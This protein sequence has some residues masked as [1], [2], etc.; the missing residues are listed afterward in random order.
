M[1]DDEESS[2]CCDDDDGFC[3]SFSEAEVA[4]LALVAAII[5]MSS[6]SMGFGP[7]PWL[8]MG[9]LIP[10]QA[11]LPWICLMSDFAL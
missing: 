5:H 1:G 2:L 9:E 10:L 3:S 11:R 7:L 6:Y 4:Y 8:L